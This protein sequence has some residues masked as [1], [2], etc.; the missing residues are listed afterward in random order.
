MTSTILLQVA[1]AIPLLTVL[2]WPHPRRSG[3]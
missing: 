2:L 3:R 1:L